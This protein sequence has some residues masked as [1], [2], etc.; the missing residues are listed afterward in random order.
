M[1]T[2]SHLDRQDFRLELS[3]LLR[4][5]LG[6]FV[7][8]LDV[9]SAQQHDGFFAEDAAV[10]GVR[11]VDGGI[12]AESHDA[13]AAAEALIQAAEVDSADAILAEGGGA[14]DAWFDSDVKVRGRKDG[15][16][17]LGDDLAEGDKFS[18]TSS[19]EVA[20]AKSGSLS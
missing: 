11:R 10:D 9:E 20:S 13:S 15:K 5:R 12:G 17:M 2:V 7:V 6:R 8:L 1:R 3:I 14:H 18:V 19:L 4:F 16:W